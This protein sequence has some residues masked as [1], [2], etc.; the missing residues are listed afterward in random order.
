MEV[1]KEKIIYPGE[2]VSQ[3]TFPTHL[4]HTY[5]FGTLYTLPKVKSA[6][7]ISKSSRYTIQ[8]ND[9]VI[10]RISARMQD[11]YRVDIGF[12]NLAYL[13]VL[14]FPQAT[15][16]NKPEL[17][18]G[19]WIM[20]RIVRIGECAVLLRCEVDWCIKGAVFEVGCYGCKVLMTSDF[21]NEVGKVYKFGIGIG[22]N[23]RIWI[24]NE[25]VEII[26]NVYDRI[27]QFLEQ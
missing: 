4:S 5:T 3:P 12:G 1:K 25:E 18:V 21:L 9:I 11:S 23:G 16:R 20:A 2:L 17:Q 14:S 27:K 24:H 15:K 10:G 6:F 26:K 19:E 7:I 8:K 13:P 22:M